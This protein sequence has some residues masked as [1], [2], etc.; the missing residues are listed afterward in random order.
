MQLAPGYLLPCISR[1]KN[2]LL[3]NLQVQ[4]FLMINAP[5]RPAREDETDLNISCLKETPESK[6]WSVNSIFCQ[7]HG[8]NKH[9][10]IAV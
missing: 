4:L 10:L 5:R 7:G 8:W 3:E 2:S 1:R 6:Y 9:K